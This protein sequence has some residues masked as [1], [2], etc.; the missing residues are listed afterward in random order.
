MVEKTKNPLTTKFEKEYFPCAKEWWCIVGY[1]NSI[2]GNN[3]WSYK[4]DFLQIMKKNK[5]PWSYY[6]LTLFDINKNK[7][8]FYSSEKDN[9]KMKTKNDNFFIQYDKSFLKGSYPEYQMYLDDKKNNISLDLKINVKSNPYWVAQKITDGCLPWG[10]GYFRYGYIPK[11]DING[12]IDIDNKKTTVKGKGYFEHVWGDFSFF[13]VLPSQRSIIKS[14]LIYAKLIG[15]WICNQESKIPNSII[16]STDNR[17]MGYD[18]IWAIL[19]NDWSLF[20][21]NLMFWLAEGPATGVLILT[22]D[23][24]KYCEF[25]NIRFKYKKLKYLEKFDLYYPIELEI[26]AKKDKEKIFF[27]IKNET[28]SIE[29]F[30]EFTDQKNTLGLLVS[31]VPCKIEGY[32]QKDNKR[33]NFRG[34]SKM[35]SHRVVRTFGHTS[36]KFNYSFSKNDFKIKSILDCHRFGKKIDLNISFLPKLKFKIKINKF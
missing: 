26:I 21:G 30:N 23:G 2:K 19:D 3:K 34:V 25:S 7:S 35:E 15:R 20:F 36:L 11:N 22:K 31:Q 9:L 24:R 33:I 16:L 18:W 10:L 5:F 28:D 4:V 13:D 12:S 27:Y 32:Y 8:Y 6:S 1:L 29:N 17:P 14:F